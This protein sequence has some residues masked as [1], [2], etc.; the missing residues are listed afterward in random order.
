M[1]AGIGRQNIIILFWK[2][3]GCTVSFLGIHKWE[4]PALHLQCP[5]VGELRTLQVKKVDRQQVSF[6]S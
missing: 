4:P 1:I 5:R 2:Y 6:H 3:K